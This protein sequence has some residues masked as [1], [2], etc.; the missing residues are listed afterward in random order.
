MR[1]RL[2]VTVAGASAVSCAVMVSPAAS[3]IAGTATHGTSP[4]VTV[5]A[6]GLNNPRHLTF[7]PGGLYV[8]E[9]GTGGPA[10]GNCV[11]APGGSGP[12]TYCEGQ[13]GSVALLRP[14][15]V[16]TVLSGLPSVI[17]GDDQEVSGAAAVTFTHGDLAVLFQ[18]TLVNKDGTSSAP[19]PA[20]T[21]DGRLIYARPHSQ[22]PSWIIGTNFAR[23]A[24]THPQSPK[25]VGGLDETTYD[26]DP[27]AIIPYD[28]GYAIA[29]GAAND[30]LWLSPWGQ[31]WLLARIPTVPETVPPG[32]LG[33]NP[34]CAGS[35]H[36]LAPLA[37]TGFPPARSLS[38]L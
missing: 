1:R 17:E 14:N 5:F 31:I 10:G 36:C 16:S 15:H 9:A 22:L 19:A 11:T 3:A 30:V 26:S 2:W 18:D 35:P 32:I 20:S 25:K 24:A 37:S 21:L 13:T 4:V 34:C 38:W 12:T 33:P 28:H 29:D 6:T 27:Y 7:G 8:T 23:F